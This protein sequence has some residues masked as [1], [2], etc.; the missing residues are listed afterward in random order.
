MD[1]PPKLK[2][3]LL[4]VVLVQ[5]TSAL[6]NGCSPSLS[7]SWRLS[8]KIQHFF[9]MTLLKLV[10]MSEATEKSMYSKITIP[11]HKTLELSHQ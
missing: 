8:K 3:A 2:E 10:F 7:S 1:K 9:I 11:L 5:T 4:L 6:W